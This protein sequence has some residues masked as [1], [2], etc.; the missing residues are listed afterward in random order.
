MEVSEVL[1]V[2]QFTGGVAPVLAQF[3]GMEDTSKQ[4]GNL[5]DPRLIQCKL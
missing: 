5:E 3:I 2:V 1:R 4:K